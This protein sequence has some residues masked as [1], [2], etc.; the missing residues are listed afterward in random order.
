MQKK[1]Q[2]DSACLGGNGC[3]QQ[4][5][6]YRGLEKKAVPPAKGFLKFH[7]NVDFT[8][9]QGMC[10]EAVRIWGCLSRVLKSIIVQT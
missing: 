5:E 2:V 6:N 4:C 3:E 8:E 10:T 1:A 7:C 9:I